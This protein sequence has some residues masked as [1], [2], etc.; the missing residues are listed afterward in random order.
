M[1]IISFIVVMIFIWLVF[2]HP[3]KGKEVQD[4]YNYFLKEKR[5]NEQKS[6]V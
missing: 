6:R 3:F 2:N 5:N 1:L 4:T